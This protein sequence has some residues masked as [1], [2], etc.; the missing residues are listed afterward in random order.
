MEIMIKTAALVVAALVVRGL[1]TAGR[2]RRLFVVKVARGEAVAVSGKVT[3]AFLRQVGE[4]AA[5]NGIRRG[6]LAGVANGSRIRLEFS[7]EFSE[8]SRQQLRNWW[9]IHGWRA[10]K[11][12]APLDSA[13]PRS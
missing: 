4:I 10:G 6:R 3:P 2:G 7:S 1:W 8:G 12:R 5:A 11:Q 9:G 13:R